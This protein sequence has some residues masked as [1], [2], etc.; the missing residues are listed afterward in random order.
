MS[1]ALRVMPE[2]R[3]GSRRSVRILER[4]IMA[5][6]RQW[7]VFVSGF[8]E[9]LFYLLSLGI[10]LNKLVGH[11][12]VGHQIVTYAAFVAPGMLAA[13]SMNGAVIDSIYNTFFKLKISHV[14]EPLL[15]TP[16]D[17][18]DIA[19]GE[20][21]W[22]LTRSTLYS[23]SFIVCMIALGD[24]HSW[25]VIACLPAAVLSSFGFACVGLAACTWV[26][27]WQDFDIVSMV[28]LPFFLFS[29]TFFPISLYPHWIATL[30]VF[31]PL[32]QSAAL[33]RGFSLGT[34]SPVMIVHAG[35]LAALGAAGLFVAT[36]RFRR[37][38]AP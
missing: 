15:A 25:W 2:W 1:T 11:L 31:S 28:Q 6:R 12:H 4:N 37:I 32:Y 26:R 27:S 10:G 13:S 30:V 21:L 16:L 34:F 20:V 23:M 7:F 17:V 29:G 3:F 36:R 38:L 8:F 19:L 35:Y 9:P 5:Y 24:F 33:L 22:S 14:Y 18:N